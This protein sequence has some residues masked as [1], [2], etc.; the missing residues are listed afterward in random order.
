MTPQQAKA[1]TDILGY[2]Q[3]LDHFQKISVLT[4]LLGASIRDAAKNT[5]SATSLTDL[6]VVQ[7]R[8]HVRGKVTAERF[9]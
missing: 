8:R 9:G 3:G 7:L 6:S 4:L 2:M 5:E 1:S